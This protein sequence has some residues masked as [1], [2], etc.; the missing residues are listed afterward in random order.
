MIVF[1][2][3]WSEFGEKVLQ[4]KKKEKKMKMSSSSVFLKIFL[5]S[6]T[7]LESIT[8]SNLFLL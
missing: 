1:S 7:D 8:S 5:D 4:K 3:I 2:Y 6:L